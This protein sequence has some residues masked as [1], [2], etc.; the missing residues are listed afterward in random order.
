MRPNVNLQPHQK[1]NLSTAKN[2]SHN[3]GSYKAPS[4]GY[5]TKDRSSTVRQTD[6]PAILEKNE[7]D[8]GGGQG[9]R[10]SGDETTNTHVA[11]SQY[12]YSKYGN[13]DEDN[14]ACDEEAEKLLSEY[15]AKGDYKNIDDDVVSVI[16][17]MI[18]MLKAQTTFV[19]QVMDDRVLQESEQTALIV[20]ESL[21]QIDY[22]LN[23]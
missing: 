2:K 22:S 17:Q 8:R 4:F 3:V 10:P 7:L 23:T 6:K 1:P 11:R 16:S 20:E 12:T 5:A 13:Q 9:K 14:G 15:V 19:P 21:K 18:P